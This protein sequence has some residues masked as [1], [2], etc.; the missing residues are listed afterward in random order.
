MSTENENSDRSQ[1]SRRKKRT[2]K[3]KPL[4]RWNYF[5]KK[6]FFILIDLSPSELLR[7]WRRYKN[8]KKQ[9]LNPKPDSLSNDYEK[10]PGFSVKMRNERIQAMNI[11]NQ[12]RASMSEDQLIKKE[13]KEKRIFSSQKTNSKS[14]KKKVPKQKAPSVWPKTIFYTA[15]ASILMVGIAYTY[16]EILG[17]KF[18][19]ETDFKVYYKQTAINNQGGE[20]A[21]LA[22][23]QIT[24][25]ASWETNDE[26]FTF[27]MFHD[28]G[29][30]IWLR[31]SNGQVIKH[32]KELGWISSKQKGQNKEWHP[33]SSD[34]Q[35]LLDHLSMP[36]A[37]LSLMERQEGVVVFDNFKNTFDLLCYQLTHT[38]QSIST[39]YYAAYKRGLTILAERII[40]STTCQLTFGNFKKLKPFEFPYIIHQKFNGEKK[41]TIRIKSIQFKTEWKKEKTESSVS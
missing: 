18:E 28:I 21:V 19:P 26:K 1:R 32:T 37:P 6:V 36:L 25:S 16:H 3:K 12:R 11:L 10:I 40:G 22:L 30:K 24:I 41:L 31:K 2:H 5:L 29:K 7:H 15:I 20:G 4:A 33:I 23:K 8:K 34:L 35:F 27:V 9:S 13:H 14:E 38:D 39:Q 17:I